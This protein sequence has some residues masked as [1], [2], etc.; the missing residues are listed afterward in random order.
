[1]TQIT[2]FEGT[3]VENWPS[4]D[5]ARDIG[6]VRPVLEADRG[7]TPNTARQRR[8]PWRRVP[9]IHGREPRHQRSDPPLIS[10]TFISVLGRGHRTDLDVLRDCLV[11]NAHD[12]AAVIME[13]ILCNTS[14]IMPDD[15]YLEGA[16]ELCNRYGSLLIFDEVITGFRVGLGGAQAR[17]GVVPGLSVFG[18][19]FGAGFRS[20]RCAVGARSW[21]SL[22][23]NGASPAGT[24]NSNVVST[25]RATRHWM[26]WP[27]TGEAC[28]A[29]W[30][31]SASSSWRGCATCP[32]E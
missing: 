20:R 15:G 8:R 12:V 32:P 25:A 4:L 18:K 10:R 28:T 22:G 17:L 24:L 26:Y 3:L 13:P 23:T 11:A 16:R 2:S 19:A 7:R 5:P 27:A 6:P 30:R 31:R 14:V 9:P 1:M 21:G 29:A